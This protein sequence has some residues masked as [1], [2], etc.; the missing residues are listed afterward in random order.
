[1]VLFLVQY[2]YVMVIKYST[3][4]ETLSATSARKRLFQL[5]ADFGEKF[6]D[7][8]RI[9]SLKGNAVLMS[10][11]EYSGMVETINIL[12]NKY[13]AKKISDGINTPIENCVAL[14]DL[15]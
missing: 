5:L 8:I 10:D 7:P 2:K 6:I 3:A 15:F 1:M 14:E 12:Q 4:M 13:L 9:T 11:E